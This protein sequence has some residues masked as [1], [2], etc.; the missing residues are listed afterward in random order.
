VLTTS[1]LC[2]PLITFVPVLVKTGF[3]AGGTQFSAAMAAFGA[4]GLL[5]AFGLLSIPTSVDRRYLASGAALAY[6]AFVLSAGVTPWLWSL[7]VILVGAGAAASMTN[8]SANT[9]VQ[10]SAPMDAL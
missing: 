5:G 10:S 1:M 9:I 7:P 8:T 6:G 4:G 3:H 2:A